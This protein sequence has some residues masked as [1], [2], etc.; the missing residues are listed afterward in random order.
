[1]RPYTEVQCRVSWARDCSSSSSNN[2]SSKSS[3][4][5]SSSSSSGSGSSNNNS[6]RSP[7]AVLGLGNTRDGSTEFDERSEAQ[8]RWSGAG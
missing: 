4:S 8:K 5:S 3:S 7:R 2:S 6:A 1:M